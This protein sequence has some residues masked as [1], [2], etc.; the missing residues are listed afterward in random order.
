M[1]LDDDFM[2]AITETLKAAASVGSLIGASAAEVPW[3]V[4]VFVVIVLFAWKVIQRPDLAREWLKIR[5][6]IEARR[7]RLGGRQL[8][9]PDEGGGFVLV[10]AQRQPGVADDVGDGHEATARQAGELLDHPL[11]GLEVDAAEA[12]VVA[13]PGCA[14]GGG[15]RGGVVAW[16]EQPPVV[17]VG[18]L[19]HRG[20]R[21][22]RQ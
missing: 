6:D 19:R 13:C 9:A 10:S 21:G 15:G 12:V 14:G 16:R 22:G 2:T 1:R 17:R 20:L 18:P 7:S 3:P 11:E 8:P 4:V 5:R